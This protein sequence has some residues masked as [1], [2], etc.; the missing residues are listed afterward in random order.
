MSGSWI[1]RERDSAREAIRRSEAARDLLAASPLRTENT[2]LHVQLSLAESYRAAG[3][4]QNANSAYDQVFAL[5]RTL[6]RDDTLTATTMFNNW[7][8]A[9]QLFGR[10]LEAEKYYRRA[11]AISRVD[12]SFE[13]VS[14]MLM[15]NYARTL[16]ELGRHGEAASYAD[17][18][19]AKAQHTGNQV[20]LNQTLF[21]GARIY[22]E[23]GDL[24]RA[25]AMLA[26]LEPRLEKSYPPGSLSFA[27]FATERALVAL[28][29]GDAPLAL[30]QTNQATQITEAA[31]A[32][33]QGAEDA[34]A[35]VLVP[36]SDIER[37][38]GHTDD[39]AKDASKAVAILQ[40]AAEPGTFSSYLGHAYYSL[41]LA[42]QA[43]GK[44]EDARA[45]FRSAAEH[46]QASVGPDYPDTRSAL[47]QVGPQTQQ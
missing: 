42:L 10:P 30:Q 34:L 21:V 24:D 36:R 33:G 6:G 12:N 47:Q 32:A 13:G 20:V 45:A 9:L 16:R 4:Y 38:V 8:F 40:K 17:R 5:L 14:P 1:A 3:Q 46:L 29:R 27:T 22:R 28:A 39:A 35:R 7:A 44:T 15:I 18:A 37:Q 2:D 25:E 23:Q 31:L 11:I 26:E 41:G 19:Y 43:Q